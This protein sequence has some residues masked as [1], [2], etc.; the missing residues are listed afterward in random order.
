MPDG[1]NMAEITSELLAE[2]IENSPDYIGIASPEGKVL[3]FNEAFR[4]LLPPH[5]YG[6]TVAS[7]TITDFHP[8]KIGQMLIESAIPEAV[9]H[10]QWH[11]RTEL[12]DAHGISFPVTQIIVAHVDASGRLLRISTMM[13]DIRPLLRAQDVQQTDAH[14]GQLQSVEV[15][16]LRQI[17]IDREFRIAQLKQEIEELKQQLAGRVA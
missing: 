15:E 4:R 2:V 12:L 17:M 10:G 6:H 13:R 3:Y 1:S 14:A 5:T 16:R 8:P 7:F 11:G 9:K